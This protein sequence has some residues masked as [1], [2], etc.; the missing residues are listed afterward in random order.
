MICV[1]AGKQTQMISGDELLS[2]DLAFLVKVL[3]R[4]VDLELR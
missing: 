4:H 1:E 2:A 3:A